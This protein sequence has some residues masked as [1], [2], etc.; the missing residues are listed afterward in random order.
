[1]SPTSPH[2]SQKACTCMVGWYCVVRVMSSPSACCACCAA[3]AAAAAASTA[4]PEMPVPLAVPAESAPAAV[5]APEPAP[6]ATP[7]IPPPGPRDG[8]R[9]GGREGR[10]V[11]PP[12]TLPP[13]ILRGVGPAATSRCSSTLPPQ[14]EASASMSARRRRSR[15][16]SLAAW[17]PAARDQEK[18]GTSWADCERHYR[19]YNSAAKCT[20]GARRDTSWLQ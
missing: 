3:C 9:E 18:Q 14:L 12:S 1:M 5:G 4:A 16:S 19:T 6:A 20:S 8:G 2:V 15:S 11:G 17:M 13:R 7:A 10:G